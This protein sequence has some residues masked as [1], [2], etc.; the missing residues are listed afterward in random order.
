MLRFTL[1]ASGL[2]AASLAACSPSGADTALGKTLLEQCMAQSPKSESC[3]CVVAIKLKH[4]DHRVLRVMRDWG[5]VLPETPEG[6][7]VLERE[8]IS[9]LEYM[10]LYREGF[11]KAGDEI[12]ACVNSFPSAQ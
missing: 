7:A 11:E 12:D 9:P 8:G 4:V 1:L 2:I 3:Y 6:K 5:D 10:R